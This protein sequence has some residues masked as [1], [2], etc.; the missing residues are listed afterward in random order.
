[1]ASSDQSE[2]PEYL[3]CPSPFQDG[4]D[5][6]SEEPNPE[7][8]LDGEARPQGCFLSVPIHPTHRKYL[9]FQWEEQAWEFQTLPF[10]LSSAPYVFTKLLK[11][12]VATLH[13][14]GM[15]LVLYLDD[16]LILAQTREMT[17]EC[18]A[19]VLELLLSLGFIIN[20]KKSVLNPTQKI[21]FLGFQIDSQRMTISLPQQKIKSLKQ[22]AR[23]L[24]RVSQ[25]SVREIAQI[26]GLMISVQPAILPA[27]LF[28][29]KIER[30]KIQALRE[31]RS[32]DAKITLTEGAK[33]DLHWWASEVEKQNGC[34]LQILQWDMVLE[35]DA[36]K[37]GWGAN[38]LGVSTG[39]LW[40]QEE[41][42][43]HINYLELLA[44]FL[45]LKTFARDCQSVAILLRIDNVTAIAFVNK[46]GGPHSTPLSNLAVEMWKWCCNRTIF[47][48]AEHLPGK[49]N[50]RAD[51]ESR[52]AKDSSDWMIQRDIFQQLEEQLGPFT[53]EPICISNECTTSNILQLDTR[54]TCSGCGCSVHP[55]VEAPALHVP[56]ICIDKSMPGQGQGGESRCTDDSPCL[57]EPGM[58]SNSTP[59][60]SE[61][62]S[63]PARDSGHT[64]RSKRKA[65]SN[66]H[67]RP[68][69]PSRLAHIRESYRSRGLSEGVIKMLSK[70][71]RSSTESAYASAWRQWSSWCAERNLHPIS[72]PVS[73]ILDF[74]LEQF[75]A[76][77]QY[78]T[79][80]TVRSVISMT[81][82]EVDGVQVGQHPLVTRFMKGVFNSR[83]PAPRYSSTWDVNIVLSYLRSL[84]DNTSLPLTLLTYKLA[85]L[86]ALS[87][88]DR[89]SDLAALDLG[90][91]S[92]QA[93]GRQGHLRRLSMLLSQ[94]LHCSARYG[95]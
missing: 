95:A 74:L 61:L 8:R 29:R 38:Y 31:L 48:H 50:V 32:Y 26:L 73:G 28:Y 66:G 22:R 55:M 72:A 34:N 9:R 59:D 30:L 36:S 90:F 76:G 84:P 4:R 10:G 83:P 89:C 91:R 39:G 58:V 43:H 7:R 64:D 88:A 15:R 65:P 53:I 2:I 49:D 60:A 27:P 12:A 57:A 42:K 77:K 18:L 63:S 1:M 13:R 44:A 35:S 87:N 21:E 6:S 62:S 24:C 23:H 86:M 14:L 41:Q 56:S 94:N 85:M 54:S 20:L 80:N 81:H 79:I 75:D 17:R 52:H 25:V 46:M 93:N 37:E 47:V 45:A 67:G 69:P 71:W 16:M 33:S 19:T 3:P 68:S 11:P 5:Q 92:F 40:T 70:S 78:R 82:S 51:W